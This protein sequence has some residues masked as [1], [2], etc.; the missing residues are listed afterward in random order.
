MAR[1]SSGRVN[2]SAS[3]HPRY[4]APPKSSSDRSSAMSCVPMAPSKIKTRSASTRKYSD[5]NFTR[6]FESDAR[7]YADLPDDAPGPI[8]HVRGGKSSQ[9]RELLL[10]EDAKPAQHGH[11]RR[12]ARS[13]AAVEHLRH[14]TASLRHCGDAMDAL[15]AGFRDDFAVA[16]EHQLRIELTGAGNVQWMGQ[17]RIA[18]RTQGR[19]VRGPYPAPSRKPRERKSSPAQAGRIDRDAA[20]VDTD[21]PGRGVVVGEPR[22]KIEDVSLRRVRHAQVRRRIRTEHFAERKDARVLSRAVVVQN[23][24]LPPLKAQRLGRVL[25]IRP[26]DSALQRRCVHADFI[27]DRSDSLDVDRL[28]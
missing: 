6:F 14:V 1:T 11:R 28:A 19:G 23:R 26:M 13:R 18:Y 5:D 7:G 16:R 20:A 24:G 22:A 27:Q 12:P 8:I 15:G 9:L 2:T 25:V 21:R 17:H 4:G 10:V 3:L